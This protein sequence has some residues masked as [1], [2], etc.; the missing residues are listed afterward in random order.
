LE[1]PIM[2]TDGHSKMTA[3]LR[4][5]KLDDLGD[6][7]N[8]VSKTRREHVD[9]IFIITYKYVELLEISICRRLLLRRMHTN[10]ASEVSFRIGTLDDTEKSIAYVSL[11]LTGAKN[12]YSSKKKRFRLCSL[13][14]SS[15]I[16]CSTGSLLTDYKPLLAIFG[17]KKGDPVYSANRY[18]R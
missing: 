4:R 13:S 3:A 7:G 17:D 18:M 1:K 2:T 9:D 10:M 12:N 14:K 5:P 11:S 6:L 16:I 8:K 15:T